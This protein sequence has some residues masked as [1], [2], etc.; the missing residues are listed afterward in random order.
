MVE[1][2]W[3]HQAPGGLQDIAEYIAR[4]S[5]RYASLIVDRLFSASEVLQDYP[6]SGRIVPELNNEEIR[7]LVEGSYGIIYLV[8]SEHQIDILTVHHSA[9][10]L[11]SN[12]RFRTRR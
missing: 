6:K 7:E 3:T 5:E 4:D 11:A 12:P 10:L 9:R 1:V 8:V 2:N